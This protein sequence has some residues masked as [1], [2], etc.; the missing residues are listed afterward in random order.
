M[1]DKDLQI[2]EY[3]EVRLNLLT[4]LIDKLEASLRERI[5]AVEKFGNVDTISLRSEIAHT[6]QMLQTAQDNL[7]L[8]SERSEKTQHDINVAS[9]EWRSTLND[10]RGSVAT[11]EEL[12]RLYAEHGAYKLENEKRT[13]AAIG[14]RAAKVESKEDWKSVAALAIAIAA[15]A[16]AYFKG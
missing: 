5:D 12:N 15:A 3:L 1:V 11:K 14:E 16:L 4:V 9:N 8:Q 7:K 10:F 6:K 2:R 13:A